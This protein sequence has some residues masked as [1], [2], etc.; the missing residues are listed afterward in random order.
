MLVPKGVST[1]RFV[2]V[3]HPTIK[4]V[5]PDSLLPIFITASIREAKANNSW[6]YSNLTSAFVVSNV[7][8]L[9]LG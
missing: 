7:G 8:S 3:Y 6:K 2:E 9:C 4:T 5:G 1:R